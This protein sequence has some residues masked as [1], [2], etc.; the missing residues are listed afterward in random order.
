MPS[1]DFY[2]VLEVAP[3]AVST[4]IRESYRKLAFRFHPDRNHGNPEASERMK[5]LNEAYA[6]LS[7]PEKRRQY[8]LMR[9]QF[10]ASARDRFRQSYSK[11]DIFRGSDIHSVFEEM[12]RAYGIRGFEEVFRD[13]YQHGP[14]PSRH[15]RSGRHVRG[16]VF[17]IPLGT[18]GGKQKIFGTGGTSRLIQYLLRRIGNVEIPQDGDDV[19]DIIT[20]SPEIAGTGG[21]YAYYHRQHSKKLIVK[22]PAAV[23]NNQRIRLSGQGQAGRYGGKNGDLYLK[24]RIHKPL[25]SRLRDLLTRK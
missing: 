12:A 14:G 21:P 18:A 25:L 1:Q 11:Q 10:G 2:E 9:S 16:F 3:D 4:D 19:T 20:L 22:I 7:D 6:V 5:Q 13:F 24:V 15:G 17:N 23:Q 8:D